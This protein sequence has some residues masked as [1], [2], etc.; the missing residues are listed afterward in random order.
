MSADQ[1]NQGANANQPSSLQPNKWSMSIIIGTLAAVLVIV[2]VAIV[3]YQMASDVTSV[4]G[5]ILPTVGTIAAAAFG[6]SVGTSV[7]TQAGAQ[8]GQAT[9]AAT[10]QQVARVQHQITHEVQKLTESV[11]SV[12]EEIRKLPYS[13]KNFIYIINKAN[14]PTLDETFRVPE[15]TL[16]DIHTRLET[17]KGLLDT[18]PT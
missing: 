18:L 14:L 9:A 4:L 10:K 8:A 15:P 1:G 2:V 12:H 3:K 17:I 13:E 6:V 11:G 7:G 5:V 16:T